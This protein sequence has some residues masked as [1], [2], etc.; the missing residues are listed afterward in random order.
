MVWN[1]KNFCQSKS[2]LDLGDDF[3]KKSVQ[4]LKF[5]LCL[6]SSKIR[7]GSSLGPK[8]ASKNYFESFLSDF[9]PKL[10]FEKKMEAV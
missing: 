5:L 7:K 3:G 6:N 4:N 1:L 9:R 10:N 2:L 8:E